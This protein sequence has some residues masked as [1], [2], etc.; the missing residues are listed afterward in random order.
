MG[1]PEPKRTGRRS[2]RLPAGAAPVVVDTTPAAPA[3]VASASPR[4]APKSPAADPM[5]SAVARTTLAALE[6]QT[7]KK[8]L[9][10]VAAKG[11]AAGKAAKG[12]KASQQTPLGRQPAARSQT[13]SVLLSDLQTE[14]P[15]IY[16]KAVSAF[17][18]PLMRG[19]P[20]P[21]VLRATDGATLLFRTATKQEAQNLYR[22]LD[23]TVV[24][25][26]KLRA[27]YH[28]VSAVEPAPS[29]TAV[30][31][32]MSAP[33]LELAQVEAVLATMPGLLAVTD[34]DAPNECLATF[35]DEGTALHARAVLSGRRQDGCHLFLS[36]RRDVTL[37]GVD[38][39]DSD[40]DAPEAAVSSPKSPAA[41]IAAARQ[42]LEHL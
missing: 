6:I 18:G 31:V 24:F 41:T 25:G 30:D 38:A 23:R 12:P 7:E 27:T 17:A 9:Q 16:S 21:T 5:E 14:L 33:P 11:A 1:K 39:S 42:A 28:P 15:V 32:V 2:T 40:D 4:Q 35:A 20:P 8:R 19:V 10:A 37:G 3:A 26:R 29:P 34:G 36:I 22:R 13:A